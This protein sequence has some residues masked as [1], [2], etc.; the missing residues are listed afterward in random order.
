MPESTRSYCR[1]VKDRKDN[2]RLILVTDGDFGFELVGRHWGNFAVLY[3]H[4]TFP[5]IQV[6]KPFISLASCSNSHRATLSTADRGHFDL[7]AMD[8]NYGYLPGED[9]L[10]EFTTGIGPKVHDLPLLE[11]SFS[12][13]A[14][15]NN[16][17]VLESRMNQELCGAC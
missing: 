1:F 7:V 15:H 8:R 4:H 17:V 3:E 14:A 13:T 11:G 5:D 9:S 16:V 10:L 12:H 2:I 6:S